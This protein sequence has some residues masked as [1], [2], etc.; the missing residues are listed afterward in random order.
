[1][2][3][4][5]IRRKRLTLLACVYAGFVFAA[6]L[7][8]RNIRGLSAS[9]SAAR[10]AGAIPTDLPTLDRPLAYSEL[11]T[12][13][14][15][16]SYKSS[17][18]ESYVLR[19]LGRLGF[20]TKPGEY[21][22]GCVFWRGELPAN[23]GSAKTGAVTKE[24]LSDYMVQLQKYHSAVAGF[25][26]EMDNR[27]HIREDVAF[28]RK[29]RLDSVKIGDFF[30]DGFLS[31]SDGEFLEPLLPTLRHPKFCEGRNHLMNMQYLIHDFEA[32]CMR[33]K[34]SSRLVF[35][36]LGA[37]LSVHSGEQPAIW[38]TEL[39][40]KFGFEFDHIYA[41]E[42]TFSSP[43]DVFNAVPSEL[44]G[45]YH[46]INS[47]VS[48]EKTSKLNPLNILKNK[49]NHEDFVVMKID[50]DTPEIELSLV[51]Q[52]LSD[53]TIIDLIDHFYFEHHVELEELRGDWGASV[54]GT[55]AESLQLF[56]ELRLK[57]LRAHYWP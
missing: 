27:R 29:L 31:V 45:A 36:D 38:L 41:F 37:S 2:F 46:W 1:M 19:N 20:V 57:G 26:L 21:A 13:T 24:R 18:F 7:T 11:Q 30:S 43:D 51:Q 52:I 15:P 49:F 42:K 33:L 32:M 28:C 5:V 22:E 3:A 9:V 4:G 39:Y 50:I 8:D 40:A 53:Q 25:R 10:S 14:V 17:V 55:V 34:P 6:F 44:L 47:G 54:N 35:F 56:H 23:D 16:Y 12:S 48:A